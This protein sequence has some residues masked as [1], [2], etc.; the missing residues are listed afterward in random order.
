MQEVKSARDAD[1]SG[2]R[3]LVRVDFNVPLKDGVVVDDARIKAALSTIELLRKNGAAKI[4]LLAHLGRPDGKVVEVLRMAPVEKKLR[5]L[6]D[7]PEVTLEEN[8]RFNPGEETNDEAFAKQLASLGDV[9][10]ND[11]FSDSHRAHASIVGIPKFLPGFAGLRFEEEFSRLSEALVPPQGALAVIGGAK[12]ETKE[13]LIQKLLGTYA[14]VLLGGALADDIIRAR[15]MPVGASLTS[16]GGVPVEVAG[17]ERL[18]VPTDAVVREVG[19]NAER[20]V[21][22]NDIRADESIID[23]GPRTSADWAQ[24]IKAAPFVLWNGPMGIYED[25]FVDGTD[26]LAQA[27]SIFGGKAVI[28]GGDT[29]AALAKFSFDTK[30][31]FVSTAGGAMLEFLTAG[32]LPGIEALRR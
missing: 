2:K 4:I 22:I 20:T 27:I 3:V 29:Q 14:Q 21:L 8:L 11:A 17:N 23:I 13:P 6:I 10:V 31:V 9:Y 5:E 12:F 16:P 7:M 28:G 24:K 26:A 19:E 32:T 18:L 25:G 30:K 1:V 15:G